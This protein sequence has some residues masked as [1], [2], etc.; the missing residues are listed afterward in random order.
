MSVAAQRQLRAAITER[1]FDRVYYL[2]GDDD[3]RKDEAAQQ[4]VDAAVD[5]EMRAFN[6]E[7][8]RANELN[9]DQLAVALSTL[10]MFGGR[11]VVVIRDVAALRKGARTALDTYLESPSPDTVLI[12]LAA[13][14]AKPDGAIVRRATEVAF[15]PL[16]SDKLSAWLVQYARRNDI[17]LNEDAAAFLVESV[18]HDLGQAVGELDKLASYTGG[19]QIEVS[20]VEAIVGVRRTETVNELLDA[21]AMRNTTRAAELTSRVLT[22]PKVTAV[23]VVSQLGMQMLG[24]AWG[25]GMVDR[26]TP[27]ARVERMLFQFIREGTYLQRPWGDAAQA[28]AR[29]IPLWSAADLRSA[30]TQLVATDLAL[31][32][33]RVSSEEATLLSLVLALCA[34]ASRRRAA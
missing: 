27:V 17:T 19:R 22:Q 10:P 8:Y 31:K 33:T 15:P 14:G 13:G 18:A 6:F 20:A 24:I 5:P 7:M 34:G 26:G 11:R 16:S 2:H 23:N 1:R 30:I 12:L 28:W 4:L 25:R 32:D 29:A 9:G 21:V 3:F